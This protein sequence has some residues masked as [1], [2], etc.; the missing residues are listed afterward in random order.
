MIL[1]GKLLLLEDVDGDDGAGDDGQYLSKTSLRRSFPRPLVPA[2]ACSPS[3][4]STIQS[5]QTRADGDDVAVDPSVVLPVV[6]VVMVVVEETD[7]DDRTGPVDD[8]DENVL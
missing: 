4:A 3:M 1:H 5:T 6:V 2:V 8:D 7:V